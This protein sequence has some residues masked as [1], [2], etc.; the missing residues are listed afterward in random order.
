MDDDYWFIRRRTATSFNIR[1]STW[2][3]W[4]V[5]IAYVAAAAAATPL[6]V[7]GRTAA[8]V[9]LLVLLTFTYGLI[10]WRKSK[11]PRNDD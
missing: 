5:T 11:P 4:A 3:G 9:M 2:Q 1:P 7:G 6:K 10:A 8:W